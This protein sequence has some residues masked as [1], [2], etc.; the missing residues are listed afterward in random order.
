MYHAVS[1]LQGW[2][3]AEGNGAEKREAGGHSRET[4]VD[5]EM[6]NVW[7]MTVVKQYVLNNTPVK[8]KNK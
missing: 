8:R 3:R 1:G 2:E 4:S 6:S 7:K 5:S